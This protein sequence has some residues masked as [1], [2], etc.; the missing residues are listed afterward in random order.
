MVEEIVP[1]GGL[2]SLPLS[3]AVQKVVG[4]D[5]LD[6]RAVYRLRTRSGVEKWIADS[7]VNIS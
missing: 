6:W 3:E 1:L 5:E 4:G 7:S 2:E